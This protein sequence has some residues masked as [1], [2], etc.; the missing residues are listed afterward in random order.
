MMEYI[1]VNGT[2]YTVVEPALGKG[3]EGAVYRILGVAESV[4][5]MEIIYLL[6]LRWVILMKFRFVKTVD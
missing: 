5:L 2:R 4:A 3:G 6:K 1:G